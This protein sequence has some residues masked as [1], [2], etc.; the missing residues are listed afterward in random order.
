MD[1]LHLA[2]MIF[3]GYYAV[4]F[5]LFVTSR[6][7]RKDQNLLEKYGVPG[8][9]TYAVITGGSDGIGLEMCH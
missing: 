2:G 5:V 3:L 8:K 7:F 4:L 9:K 6:F 1:L